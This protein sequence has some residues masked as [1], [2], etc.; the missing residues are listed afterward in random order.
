[1][2]ENRE[3]LKKV[4]ALRREYTRDGIT[5]DSVCRNP[6][7]QFSTWFEKAL[8]SG[9]TDANAMVL[10][11]AT[12]AGKPSA[13]IVLLKGFDEKGF[14]FYSNYESR[15][16]KEL[17]ENPH[18]SLC[19]YWPSLERQVRIEGDVKKLGR[20]ESEAY[21]NSRPRESQIGAWVSRQSSGIMSRTELEENFIRL[22]E[23]FEGQEVPPPDF[24]GGYVLSPDAI[25]F[26]QGRRSRLHDRILYS[27]HKEEWEITRLAP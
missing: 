20:K 25:E 10:A 17:E 3:H 11:T 6:I 8:E 18:A 27:R 2:E 4:E 9:Q 23:E 1:M 19:F 13:R 16:G 24:W 22:K 5:E 26:W 21:F 15:K 12:S 7:D 14:R